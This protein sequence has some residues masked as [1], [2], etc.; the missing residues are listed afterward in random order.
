MR[1][2]KISNLME[3]RPFT[4]Q[5]AAKEYFR[6]AWGC[7]EAKDYS[8]AA[9]YYAKAVELDHPSA[10]N[11]LGNLYKYGKGVTRDPQ[12]AFMLFEAAAKQGNIFG[13]KNTA[14]CY[15]QGFGVAADREE[16][17]SWLLTA[18]ELGAEDVALELAEALDKPNYGSGE[19]LDLELAKE[20]YVRATESDDENIK[21]KAARAL[22]ERRDWYGEVVSSAM[23]MGT[24]F[25]TYA[26]L[27]QLGNAEAMIE[28]GYCYEMGK[29]V[30]EDIDRAI[31]WYERAGNDQ[32]KRRAQFCKNKKNDF[33][34]VE[35][36][37]SLGLRPQPVEN[38]SLHRKE[39]YSGDEN[40]K[41]CYY[42]GKIYYLAQKYLCVVDMGFCERKILA[43]D[44][45]LF[46]AGYL[47]VNR[48]GIYIY[49]FGDEYDD[50]SISIYS[51]DGCHR[52]T[53]PLTIG[54]NSIYLCDSRM[55]YT[56][57]KTFVVDGEEREKYSAYWMDLEKE[58]VHKIYEN[59]RYIHNLCGD[60]EKAVL[61]IEFINDEVD[62]YCMDEGWY[63]F[64]IASGRLSCISSNV[65]PPHYVMEHP[66][67]YDR[68]SDSYVSDKPRI[69]IAWVDLLRNIVWI[70]EETV[71]GENSAKLQKVEFWK[72]RMLSCKGL[73]D[74]AEDMPIW[75]VV[76]R[77]SR[78]KEYFDGIRYYSSA[79]YHDFKSYDKS[80]KCNIWNR[81]GHGG[82]N[83][84]VV[85]DEFLFLDLEAYGE[86]QYDAEFM[87]S[88]PYRKTDLV[89]VTDEMI[90]G[91]EAIGVK[92][93]C[94]E[95]VIKQDEREGVFTN[96]AM[97]GS[98]TS[99]QETLEWLEAQVPQKPK[100]KKTE[101]IA[102]SNCL[103]VEK[104][105]GT[106]DV[107]YKICTAG[108][109]FDI[110]Q[111]KELTVECDG[112]QYKAKMHS[113]AKGRIDGLSAMYS[114]VGVQVGDV[115]HLTYE[116]ERNTIVFKKVN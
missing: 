41:K 6:Q 8:G 111:G 28:Y 72:P 81:S 20:W 100:R 36:E 34:N 112:K 53:V 10:Q 16:Y 109:K 19:A 80:G 83:Y 35:Y 52:K 62:Y 58:S 90:A 104:T 98:E 46:Y 91:F 7:Y 108:A 89:Y 22:D 110:G 82:C 67:V 99:F 30:L 71:E 54:T 47:A 44:D 103:T 12:K 60:S 27:A 39:L 9:A 66:E 1:A 64:H 42:D 55:Y 18:A 85:M 56:T 63:V 3:K 59:A 70:S 78:G 61:K 32:G 21:L 69:E 95:S 2:K 23:D 40:F 96:A 113:S 79:H 68:E 84:F 94:N 77:S 97:G 101:L 88:T 74:A 4:E 107:K 76:D 114:A 57:K 26:Y 17:A 38:V 102:G 25:L 87:L 43:E 37:R 49:E 106:T 115:Y 15:K 33:I 48:T 75:K 116:E 5:K 24:A 50:G 92:K 45:E 73:G 11:N 14:L 65:C 86:E 31:E 13:Q 29:F 93:I 105:M 51:F